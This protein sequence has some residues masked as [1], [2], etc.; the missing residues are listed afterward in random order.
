MKMM[1]RSFVF[2]CR[3]FAYA[4][5]RPS[6]IGEEADD[7]LDDRLDDRNRS[8]RIACC[9]KKVTSIQRTFLPCTYVMY[10]TMYLRSM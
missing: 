9:R 6:I 1:I 10:V 3:G 7:R 2:L 4:C 8:D 5:G